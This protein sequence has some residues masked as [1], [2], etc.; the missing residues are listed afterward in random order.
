MENIG[1]RDWLSSQGQSGFEITYFRGISSSIQR[2]AT[3][4]DE[5][6]SEVGNTSNRGLTIRLIVPEAGD[7]GE[8]LPM[9]AEQRPT[10]ALVAP[11]GLEERTKATLGQGNVPALEW[12]H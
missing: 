5:K 4:T 10:R 11:A 3:C 1:N 9:A 2:T 7:S 8:G 6:I 12:P